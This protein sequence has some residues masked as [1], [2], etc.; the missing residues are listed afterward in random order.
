MHKNGY[1]GRVK[2]AHLDTFARKI[3]FVCRITFDETDQM[4]YLI[5]YVTRALRFLTTT[6]Y[7][8]NIRVS[9]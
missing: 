3:T 9:F 5:I 8:N 1:A 6:T 2:Y 4:I 7:Y